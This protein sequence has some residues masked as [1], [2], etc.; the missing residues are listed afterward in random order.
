MKAI[1]WSKSNCVYCNT[2]KRT[3]AAHGIEVEER[4]IESADWN[5]EQLLEAVPGATFV[6]QI[7]IDGEYIGSVPALMSHISRNNIPK[8][9]TPVTPSGEVGKDGLEEA[10]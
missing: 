7:F 9:T 8:V 5:K 3:L 4:N 1:V 6:P 2:A 10:V